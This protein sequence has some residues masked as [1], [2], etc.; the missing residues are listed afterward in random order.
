MTVGKKSFLDPSA[1]ALIPAAI[2][3]LAGGRSRRFGSDKKAAIV[4][5]QSLAE[6]A[7]QLAASLSRSTMWISDTEAPATGDALFAYRDIIADLG[8]LGGLYTALR[9]CS[10]KWLL[11]MPVDMPNLTAEVFHA[12]WQHRHTEKPVVVLS[13]SGLESLLA[14]WPCALLS[15]VEAFIESGA[16]AMHQLYRK[17]HAQTLDLGKQMP[18]G[19][20][21]NVN[22]PGD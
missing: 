20:F 1:E 21:R 12:L 5:G 3:V 22:R 16:R 18:A 7:V 4:R 15:R 2:A 14:I 10:G 17:C 8:P 11:I 9:H 19:V 13:D 6:R